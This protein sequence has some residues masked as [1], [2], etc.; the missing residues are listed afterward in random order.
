MPGWDLRLSYRNR[1]MLEQREKHVGE[2]EQPYLVTNL[3]SQP[4]AQ[5]EAHTS[6][7]LCSWLS[8]SLNWTFGVF[9]TIDLLKRHL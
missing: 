4:I 2:E 8:L 3:P 9:Q 6:F 7:S 5:F 1:P